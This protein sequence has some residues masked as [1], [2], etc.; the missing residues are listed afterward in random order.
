VFK[1]ALKK[2]LFTFV[3]E[4]IKL[5]VDP[6]TIFF[7]VNTFMKGPKRYEQFIKDLYNKDEKVKYKLKTNTIV[8]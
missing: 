5:G 1:D 4:F 6:A 2:D 3:Y 7:P 8:D